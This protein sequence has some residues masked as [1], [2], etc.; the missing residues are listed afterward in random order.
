MGTNFS[1]D[2]YSLIKS[3]EIE[4]LYLYGSSVNGY[5]KEDS[6]LDLIAL[7]SKNS[8]R[9]TLELNPNLSLHLTHPLTFQS[10]ELAHVYTHLRMVPI[11]NKNRCIEISNKMKSELVRRELIRF[12]KAGIEEFKLLDPI[13]NY[14]IN[15]GIQRP[16]RINHIKR[17]FESK[18]TQEILSEEYKIVMELLEERKMIERKGARFRINQDYFFD[19]ENKES[20]DSVL[21]KIKNSF[22]GLHYLTNLNSIRNFKKIRVQEI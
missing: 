10:F 4:A 16:W 2:F 13:N 11:Y 22:L 5:K 18:E 12:R 21:F 17:I 19:E 8:R 7:T 14:L 20:R 6:D 1:N 9:K 3:H 15:H